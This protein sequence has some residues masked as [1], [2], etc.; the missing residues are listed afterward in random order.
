MTLISLGAM[1]S[2]KLHVHRQGLLAVTFWVSYNYPCLS[3]GLWSG[4]SGKYDHTMTEDVA[5]SPN[6][7]Q[8]L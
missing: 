3:V 8:W 7:D 5:R 4:F 6:F 1:S 2:D